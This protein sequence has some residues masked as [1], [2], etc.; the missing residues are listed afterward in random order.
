MVCWSLS[1][2]PWTWDRDHG[3]YCRADG[4]GEVIWDTDDNHVL[5]NG[6]GSYLCK[7]DAEKCERLMVSIA[8]QNPRTLHRSLTV[9]SCPETWAY[10]QLDVENIYPSMITRILRKFDVRG[11]RCIDHNGNLCCVPVMYEAW[12]QNI[13]PLFSEEIRGAILGNAN[14]LLYIKS[15][16]A[17]CH[18]NPRILNKHYQ[19]VVD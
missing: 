16:I 14:L 15:L 11:M 10:D 3:A 1:V 7:V 12:E 4:T 19:Q 17:Q 13:V 18:A 8:D 5:E 6:Y 9:I 2:R